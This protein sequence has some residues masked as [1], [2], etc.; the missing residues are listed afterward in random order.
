MRG[1]FQKLLLTRQGEGETVW[2]QGKLNGK[3]ESTKRIS[4]Q[5][6]RSPKLM[7][8]QVNPRVRQLTQESST[9]N[10]LNS[11]STTCM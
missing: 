10:K 3:R 11:S 5:A 6:F 1:K 8:M 9:Q 7:G 4:K 2:S